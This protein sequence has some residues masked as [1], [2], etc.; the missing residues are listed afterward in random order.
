MS[1]N[2]PNG[3]E[4][5][6]GDSIHTSNDPC[7]HLTGSMG[8]NTVH[9]PYSGQTTLGMF[10]SGLGGHRLG[11]VQQLHQQFPTVFRNSGF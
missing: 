8:G 10:D 6:R 4:L 11:D 1:L 5:S 9:L 2:L 7:P 3:F